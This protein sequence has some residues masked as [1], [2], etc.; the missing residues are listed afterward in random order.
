MYVLR[1]LFAGNEK[2]LPELRRRAGAPA[3]AAGLGIVDRCAG[4]RRVLDPADLC[5][6]LCSDYLPLIPIL[7]L[8]L[9][10][11]CFLRQLCH[12]RKEGGRLADEE[13]HVRQEL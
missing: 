2:R 9:S 12:V 11:V 1:E 13:P 4:I 7:V 8:A 6:A 10:R 5:M 3:A